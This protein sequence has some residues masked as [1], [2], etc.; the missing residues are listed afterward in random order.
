MN[1]AE[2]WALR[3]SAYDCKIEWIPGKQN[4][5]D[6]SSRLG[7]GSTAPGVKAQMQTDIGALEINWNEISTLT[8]T[9][10]IREIQKVLRPMASRHESLQVN[11]RRFTLAA[12][13]VNLM[14]AIQDSQR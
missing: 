9:L 2:G 5:S 14:P 6:P 1:R 10:T 7:D 4:I 13:T 8:G 12:R 3:L 11:G